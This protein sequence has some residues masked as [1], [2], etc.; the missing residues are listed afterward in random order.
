VNANLHH[1]QP[2]FAYLLTTAAADRLL[3]VNGMG[4]FRWDNKRWA[5]DDRGQVTQEILAVLRRQHRAGFGNPDSLKEVKACS[6]DSAVRGIAN[7]ASSMPA[8]AATVGDLDADPFVLNC[9]NGTLDL[10]DL[11]LK[12]HRPADRV[13][14]VTAAGYHPEATSSLWDRFLARVLPDTEVRTYVQRFI[15]VS[16]LGLVREHELH[17]AIGTGRNGKGVFVEAVTAALGDYAHAAPADLL[18]AA[19][20]GKGRATPELMSLRGTRFV[21]A[22]ETD[23][24]RAMATA[25]VKSLTGGDRITAR[26]LYGSPVTFTPSHSLLLATNHAPK[27]PGDDLAL[28]ARLRVIPFTVF[29]PEEERD[30]TLKERLALDADA[31]LAWA[32]AGLVDYRQRG[33]MEP[34][35]AVTAATDAYRTS[36][37]AIGRFITDECHINPHE[38]ALTGELF[39]RWAKWAAEDGCDPVGKRAFGEELT[40]RGFEDHKGTGGVRRRRGIALVPSDAEPIRDPWESR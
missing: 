36:S 6:P 7:L 40:R 38:T 27:V 39:A 20:A 11:T 17:L 24:G 34:P 19:K 2:K 5:P 21:A 32:V 8:F 14:K 16:L 22:Q 12:P 15:G 23:E 10:H 4:W 37:D 26:P 1:G 28:W 29:I 35:A 3:H 31:I 18:L 30:A 25:T 9:A 13:T 33:S